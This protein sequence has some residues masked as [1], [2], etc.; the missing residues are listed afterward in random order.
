MKALCSV[1]RIS[2]K[3]ISL[4]LIFSTLISCGKE[5]KSDTQ[6][7]KAMSLLEGKWV[8]ESGNS[9]AIN[10][11]GVKVKTATLNPGVVA[12]EFFSDGR[13]IGYDNV[14]NVTEAG[15]WKLEEVH[16]LNELF[17]TLAITTPSIQALKGELSI[18][19]DGFQRYD[20]EST[21]NDVR[22][23]MLTSKT[24]AAYPYEKNWVELKFKKQ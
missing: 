13:Y 6:T 3:F 20:I 4:I 18:D 2:S 22:S 12:H 8:L 23:F 1:L 16:L 17:A 5:E 14:S 9:W 15:Q 7:E 21:A 24:Y 10:E 11:N 19:P